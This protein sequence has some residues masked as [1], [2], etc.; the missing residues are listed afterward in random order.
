MMDW[1]RDARAALGGM[2]LALVTVLATEGSAP[3]GAGT[4]MVVTAH[5]IA[6]TIGGGRL[7]HQAVDQARALL[8]HPPGTW[9]VQDYALGPLLGQCCGG[10]VRLL[11]EQLDPAAARWLDDAA[12]GTLIAHR[13]EA[14]R[15]T[16]D[17]VERATP[18]E[19]F[20][21]G[22]RLEAGALAVERLDPPGRPLLLFGAGHVGRAIAAR[23]PGLPFAL[24]WFDSRADAAER[25]GVAYVPAEEIDVCAADAPADAAVL[26]LT[27]DHA[28]DYRLVVA[29]LRGPACF[30]GLIGSATKR[31]RFLSRLE[32]DGFDAADRAGLT[33]PIGLPGIAGKEPEVIA[34]AALAQ[35]LTLPRTPA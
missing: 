11:V 26:I 22:P 15:I 12:A 14:G 35:L 32:K 24:R 16:R 29:A 20:A 7:E 1:A 25:P 10:R 4:R 34:I 28:L 9:R 18:T 21:R 2:P 27:H 31:A 6:G 5:G 19:V 23:C 3:R 30:V 33:C 17:I 8:G 13:F